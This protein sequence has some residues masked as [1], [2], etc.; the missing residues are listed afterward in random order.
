MRQSYEVYVA[1][2]SQKLLHSHKNL[3]Q[4]GNTPYQ[5]LLSFALQKAGSKLV[6]AK[7]D[8][9]LQE[10]R[11]YLQFFAS[12]IEILELPAWD[13]RPYD[14]I[15]PR[16]AISAERTYTLMRLSQ[17]FSGIVLTTLNSAMQKLPPK[18]LMSTQGM[19]FNLGHELDLEVL[20]QFAHRSG[21]EMVPTVRMQGEYSVRGGIVD[22]YPAGR[23]RP[24][25]I[26]LFGDVIDRLRQFDPQSQ[27][28]GEA[29]ERVVLSPSDELIY[30]EKT[31]ESFRAGYRRL[32][33][34][35]PKD[36][37]FYENVTSG[38]RPQG[39]EHY[40]PLF[41]PE[42]ET[43]G[44]YLG[45]DWLVFVRAQ[46]QEQIET[47]FNDIKRHQQNKSEAQIQLEA[48][49]LYLDLPNFLKQFSR[50]SV[51]VGH[52]SAIPTGANAI[53]AGFAPARDF[54]PE[55]ADASGKLY[56]ELSSYILTQSKTRRIILA[57]SS[58]GSRARMQNL[59]KEYG[60]VDCRL[61]DTPDEN[62]PIGL[63]VL[64]I[65]HGIL[66]PEYL[67]LSEADIL[68][69]RL[70]RRKKKRRSDANLIGEISNLSVGDLVVHRDHGIARFV[71]MQ[72]IEA[73][74][75]PHECL[76]L[77]YQGGDKLF[78]PAENI[79]V[80]SPYGEENAT[81]D[82]LGASNWQERKARAKKDLLAMADGLIKI[83][84]ER[85]LRKAP[86]MAVD[87][88]EYEGFAARFPFEET[89]DQSLAIEETLTD[90]ASGRPM[91]RLVCGDVGFGKTEVAMRAAFVA[92]MSG[93]QVA[94]ISPTTLLSRQHTRNFRERFQ[95]T[96]LIVDQLSRFVSAQNQKLRKKALEDGKLDII[97]GTHA[98]LSNDVKFKNLGL[99]IVDEEQHFGVKHKEKIKEL[100]ADVHVLTLSATPIPRTL[101]LALTGVRELS[102]IATPPV[103]RLS[104][105]TYVAPF[106]RQM[107]RDALM[108]EKMRGG[109]SF[110]VVPRIS[111]L[112]ELEEFLE[113][114]CPE[115]RVIVAHGQ[116]PAKELDQK[117]NDFYDGKADVLLATT[118]IESGIDIP[119]ANTLIVHRA[120]MFGLAQL[121]QIRGRVGR[122]KLRAFAYLTT[123]PKTPL[124][125]V[126]EKRLR[127]LST[128]DELGSGFN[129]ASFDLDLRGAGNLL[130]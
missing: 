111:D 79:D 31:I 8:R 114:D 20:H 47:R 22:I 54:A 25:R 89:D 94:V 107:V 69:E 125:P 118:I 49:A 18:A 63:A 123:K 19:Q 120:D 5:S 113:A 109:Q 98:L 57:C 130:G 2:M 86:I 43:L 10:M 62:V 129:L 119:A 12:D 58:E 99:L 50:N 81:L 27:R 51:Y 67:L 28:S 101:Q 76:L 106:E 73:A 75:A 33:G 117:V 53:D 35:P 115:L 66:S 15:S 65:S 14:R 61:I 3:T 45:E 52:F 41:Y 56:R 88:R 44:D 127:V 126:A 42:L 32:H 83:A 97:I 72:S 110:Y 26:D 74:G 95:G 34:V 17:G 71:G 91:D 96:G 7:D 70:A 105:R 85:N 29:L 87:D 77:E 1:H 4:I 64:P 112:P 128:L 37:P 21:Y 55:R 92:A 39:I 122:S 90:L 59:L 24:V 103:D 80:L 116:L 102:L 78:V 121:Y 48:D 13:C 60:V 30:S 40:L 93:Y 46:Y 124:N 104:T 16:P 108:Q 38:I 84:A 6:I 100:R 68:G 23:D 82:K 11:N 36:D 9:D